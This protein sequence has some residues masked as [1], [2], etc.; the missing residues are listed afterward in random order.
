MLPERDRTALEDMLAHAEEA[1]EAAKGRSRSDLE[2][3][4]FLCLGLQH[5]I[6]IVGEAAGRV[7]PETRAA[8][9]RIPWRPFIRMR[10]RL[11][12]GYDTVRPHRVWDTVTLDLPPLIRELRTALAPGTDAADRDPGAGP[13]R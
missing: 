7:S 6:A 9:P 12:H 8:Y 13:E 3:D 4:R 1:V 10:N 2:A 5:L 11:I